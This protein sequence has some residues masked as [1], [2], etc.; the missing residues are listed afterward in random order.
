MASTQGRD[1]LEHK[2]VYCAY[3]TGRR[4]RRARWPGRA[5]DVCMRR[6]AENRR[7]AS[8]SW[9]LLLLLLL[10]IFLVKQNGAINK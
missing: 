3:S 1:S 10:L 2:V 5:W 7:E 8:G 9:K 6:A 4:L